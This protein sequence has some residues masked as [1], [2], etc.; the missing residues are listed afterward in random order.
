MHDYPIYTQTRT[1]Q[2]LAS[3]GLRAKKSLGQHFMIDGNVLRAMVSAVPLDAVVIEIG[4]GLGALT[5]QLAQRAHAVVAI[6]IDAHM[7]RVLRDV[8]ASYARVHIVHA[9]VLRVQWQQLYAE[10]VAPYGKERPV[11]VV[12]NL[13]YYVTTP[14]V[15]ALLRDAAFVRTAIVMM[16]EE[17]CARI[18]A[19]PCTKAYG[20]LSIAIA[21]YAHAHMM[22]TIPPTAFFPPPHV[23]SAVMRLDRRGAPPVTVHDE[24]VF[25]ALVRASFA[26]RRKTLSNNIVALLPEP[27]AKTVCAEWLR[28]AGI[29]GQR[30]GETL[31]IAQFAALANYAPAVLRTNG[32]DEMI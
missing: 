10:I 24:H 27:D 31:D 9:D 2:L 22:R 4:P 12:A 18:T 8:L 15:L 1:K 21:Y 19:S 16:Q 26:H 28:R 11:Y 25:F 13:P 5:E 30:R 29:D 3:Y 6:E 23:Q 14:I 32:G 7:V 20:S 17:V